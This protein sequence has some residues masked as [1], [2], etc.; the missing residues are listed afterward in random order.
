MTVQC[1]YF[2][3]SNEDHRERASQPVLYLASI[4][5]FPFSEKI[6]KTHMDIAQKAISIYG[7]KDPEV[8]K[9]TS[10]E[11]RMLSSVTINC[12]IKKIVMYSGSQL[13]VL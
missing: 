1:T 12:Q 3:I 4:A 8:F 5:V 7:L 11:L 6:Q 13:S 9:K 10:Q 2:I